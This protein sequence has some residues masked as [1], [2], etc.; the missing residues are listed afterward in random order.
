V[1][2]DYPGITNLVLSTGPGAAQSYTRDWALLGPLTI[3]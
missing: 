2:V 3:E 1:K